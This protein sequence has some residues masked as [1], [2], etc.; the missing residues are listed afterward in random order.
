M[1]KSFVIIALLLLAAFALLAVRG[2]DPNKEYH[3]LKEGNI[4]G[5]TP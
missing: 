3:A 4:Y 1:L 2:L 5:K